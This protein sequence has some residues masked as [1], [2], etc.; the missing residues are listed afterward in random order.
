MLALGLGALTLALILILTPILTLSW[1]AAVGSTGAADCPQ[2]AWFAAGGAT[3]AGGAPH[4]D[5]WLR[6]G[7]GLGSGLALG[8]GLGIGFG[9]GLAPNGDIWLEPGR[10]VS[11]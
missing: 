4:G 8:L 11:P 3:G 2:D 5:I 7:L 10:P 9:L 1:Q 6:L